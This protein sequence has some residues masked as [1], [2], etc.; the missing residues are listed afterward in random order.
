MT[1][2]NGI[3]AAY[4]AQNGLDAN[5]EPITGDWG[6]L[7]LYNNELLEDLDDTSGDQLALIRDG[8]LPKRFP[9]CGSI[10]RTLD[11]ILD[12]INEHAISADQIEKIETSVPELNFNN[13]KYRDP[14]T[15]SEA[16]FS[17]H[18]C[19]AALVNTGG[20]SLSDFTYAAVNNRRDIRDYIG[21]IV[22][23]KYELEK[24]D[25]LNHHLLIHRKDG[26][27]LK[28]SVSQVKGSN[29]NPFSDEDRRVKFYDCVKE[30]L[31]HDAQENLYTI[32]TGLPSYSD[33]KKITQYL[34]KQ[35]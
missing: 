26:S 12:L 35:P 1:A 23:T 13:L 25:D 19:I 27:S 31:D 17:M 14:A 24:G 8:L 33:I 11:G 30:Y 3:M 29:K 32:L 7:D 4:L 21:R 34:T 10:H 20:L 9:C 18:Y 16:R 15:A 28:K 6:F 2:Q 22:M 5:S